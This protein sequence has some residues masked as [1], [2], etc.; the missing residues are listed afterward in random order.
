[1]EYVRLG[2]SNL[3][4]SRV[5]MGAMNLTAAGDDEKAA[6]LVRSAYEQG[7]NFLIH[8]VQLR[9]AKSFWVM[10]LEIFVTMLWLPQKLQLRAEQKFSA[11]LKPVL[12]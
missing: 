4:I 3:M 6:Q 2:R 11:I 12:I 9:S 10:Q 7:I 1:M 8:P 5:A